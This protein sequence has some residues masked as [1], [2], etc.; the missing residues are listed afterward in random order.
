LNTFGSAPGHRILRIHATERYIQRVSR[1]MWGIEF[2]K[3]D[4]RY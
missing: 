3:Q 4:N 2:M 1:E